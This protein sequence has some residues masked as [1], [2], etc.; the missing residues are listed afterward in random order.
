MTTASRF[1]AAAANGSLATYTVVNTNAGGSGVNN[2]ITVNFANQANAD[3]RVN[4]AL[5]TSATTP[6]AGEYIEYNA[7]IAPYG[8]LERT[9]III[10]PG[11]SLLASANLATTNVIAWG[12]TET[13]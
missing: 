12:I 5:S 10:P 13:V 4:L 1:V 11:F 7:L 9:G 6:S 8:V 2:V 3:T